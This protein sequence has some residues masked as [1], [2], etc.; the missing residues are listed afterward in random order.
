MEDDRSSDSARA[1]R[2]LPSESSKNCDHGLVNGGRCIVRG[3]RDHLDLR[4]MP[5]FMSYINRGFCTSEQ[6]SCTDQRLIHKAPDFV[7]SA[8]LTELQLLPH[9]TSLERWKPLHCYPPM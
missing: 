7:I 4:T 2:K 5:I 8:G 3:Q 6:R 9:L 1:A